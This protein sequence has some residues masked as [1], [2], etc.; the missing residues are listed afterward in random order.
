M[1][2]SHSLAFAKDREDTTISLLTLLSVRTV[3]EYFA[4]CLEWVEKKLMLGRVAQVTASS[5]HPVQPQLNVK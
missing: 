1:G 3:G 2:R 4:T 5:A